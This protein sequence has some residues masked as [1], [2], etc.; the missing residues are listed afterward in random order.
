MARKQISTPNPQVPMQEEEQ[1]EAQVI[2]RRPINTAAQI[3]SQSAEVQQPVESG[4]TVTVRIPKNF[5]LTLAD[6]TQ[7]HYKVGVDEMPIEHA[8]HW[9]SVASGVEIYDSKKS[10]E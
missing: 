2:S 7:V 5:S 9:Y 3:A 4:K 6:F 10:R 8:T 1:E